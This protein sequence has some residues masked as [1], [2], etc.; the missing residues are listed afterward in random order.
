MSDITLLPPNS[1]QHERALEGSTARISDI[2]VPIR[3]VMNPYTCPAALLPWLAWSRSVDEWQGSWTEEEKRKVIAASFYV[4]KKKGTP[5]AVQRA[6]EPLGYA[7]KIVEWWEETPKGAPYSFRLEV[8]VS[9]KG[10]IDAIYE[11]IDA[12]VPN[13]KNSRSYMTKLTV[14]ADVSGTA[15]INLGLMSGEVTEIYPF[16][17][18]SLSSAGLAYW[19]M[20]EHSIDSVNIYPAS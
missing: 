10:L 17:Q 11:Q 12:L 19:G 18:E 16:I 15:F 7:V 1:T 14:S 2:P 9:N 4:H 13:N 6:L 3:D 8:G 5:I 20:A